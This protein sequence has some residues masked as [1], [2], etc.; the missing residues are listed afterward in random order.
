MVSRC[1]EIFPVT[2]C[3]LSRYGLRGARATKMIHLI[4]CHVSCC[5]S[6]FFSILLSYPSPLDQGQNALPNL[7]LCAAYTYQVKKAFF[8]IFSCLIPP[9][10]FSLSW[11]GASLDGLNLTV[12]ER[13]GVFPTQNCLMATTHSI[14]C[15]GRH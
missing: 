4:N 8:F 2:E 3:G 6:C 7:C 5:I 12:E 15:M 9:F 11:Q 10:L 1:T 14:I 13:N